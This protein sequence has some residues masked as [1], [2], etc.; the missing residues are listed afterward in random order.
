MAKLFS[1][2]TFLITLISTK[3]NF[4]MKSLHRQNSSFRHNYYEKLTNNANSLSL[5]TFFIEMQINICLSSSY[6][7]LA[8]LSDIILEICYLYYQITPVYP[9]VHIQAKYFITFTLLMLLI[10]I[11][12]S[13]FFPTSVGEIQMIMSIALSTNCLSI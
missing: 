12:T 6:F 9:L 2:C 11:K 8:K 3:D 13:V 10:K 7:L 5:C 1:C 4:G